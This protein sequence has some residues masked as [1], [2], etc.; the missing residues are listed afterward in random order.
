MKKQENNKTEEQL[1]VGRI[2]EGT[3]SSALENKTIHVVVNTTKM[4][5]KYRKQYVVSKKYAV[6]DEK[7][8][9]KEGD[10]VT[11]QECRPLSKTKRWRLVSVK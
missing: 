6:H 1:A 10:I 2:I 5:V 7:G 9:A 3:V 8:L 11:F 4:H